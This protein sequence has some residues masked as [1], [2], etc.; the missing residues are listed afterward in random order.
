V[1]KFECFE[2]H[3]K[4]LVYIYYLKGIERY[5]EKGSLPSVQEDFVNFGA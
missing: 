5:G 2:F 1:R 4:F 3:E